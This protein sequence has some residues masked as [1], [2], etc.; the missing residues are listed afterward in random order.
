VHTQE[1]N[2]VQ[3]DCL[4]GRSGRGIDLGLADLLQKL[5]L[6]VRIGQKIGVTVQNA[7][8]P[9]LRPCQAA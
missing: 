2:N 4:A 3:N 9:R 5:S 8:A 6:A 7:Y 1:V